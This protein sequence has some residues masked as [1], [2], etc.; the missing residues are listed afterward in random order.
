[1]LFTIFTQGIWSQT[2]NL[3]VKGV[4]SSIS[5]YMFSGKLQ[6][7]AQGPQLFQAESECG[8]AGLFDCAAG[9]GGQQS[10]AGAG[11]REVLWCAHKPRAQ[12]QAQRHAL[13]RNG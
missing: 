2:G 13:T 8:E 6:C 10:R 9:N 11:G 3:Y 7:S 12:R 4:S 5:I 1:M